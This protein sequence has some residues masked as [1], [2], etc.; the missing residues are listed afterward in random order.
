MKGV[1]TVASNSGGNTTVAYDPRQ[2]WTANV[3]PLVTAAREGAAHAARTASRE[4]ARAR[5]Q[6]AWWRQRWVIVTAAGVAVVAA[7]GGVYAA[8]ASRRSGNHG[9]GEPTGQNTGF[10]R[11]HSPDGSNGLK[12]TMDSGRARVTD[13][14][15]N[16]VHKLRGNERTEFG[17]ETPRMAAPGSTMP[18]E[19]RNELHS[20]E[21]GDQRYQSQP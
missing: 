1:A 3:A 9:F 18:D 14:A 10:E 15:R 7:A 6:P 11:M 8:V 4:R 12:S 13:V 2:L 17:P 5:Q 16:M 20:A 19:P 21:T